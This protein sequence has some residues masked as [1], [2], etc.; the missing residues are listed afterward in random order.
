MRTAMTDESKTREE[1][2]NEVRA[3]RRQLAARA[4]DTPDTR[5]RVAAHLDAVGDSYFT[6]DRDWRF[7]YLNRAARARAGRPIEELLGR[8]IWETYPALLGTPLEAH[9]R[10]AMATGEMI[11]VE[12]P[13]V[14][15]DHWYEIFAR[16]GPQGLTV[17]SRD[18]T[19]RRQAE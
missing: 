8:T 17:Y 2:L 7:I 12:F 6:L 11:H 18:I 13:A 1:L 14:L 3:L 10:Q 9:Y 4:P 16:S 5:A 19:A 15:S